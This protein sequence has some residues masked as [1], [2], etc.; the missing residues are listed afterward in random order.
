MILVYFLGVYSR[1]RKE[2][3]DIAS[4]HERAGLFFNAFCCY[5]YLTTC[6][7]NVSA[8]PSIVTSPASPIR[9]IHICIGARAFCVCSLCLSYIC[10]YL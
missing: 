5:F 10:M 6:A 3:L 4:L 2:Q 8:A 1:K 9:R 7:S